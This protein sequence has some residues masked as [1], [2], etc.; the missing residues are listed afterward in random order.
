MLRSMQ[1]PAQTQPT[2]TAESFAGLLATLASPSRE[3]PDRDSVFDSSGLGEDVATLSYERALRAHA[4]Y[5]PEERD[6]W[7]ATPELSGTLQPGPLAADRTGEGLPPQQAS[8]DCDLRTMSVTIRLSKPECARLHQRAAEAGV[9]VSAYLR[10]CT[11]EAEALRAQVKEA[12]AELRLA[13]GRGTEGPRDQG[14]KGLKQ[15]GNEGVRLA[16][17]LAHMGNLWIGLASGKSS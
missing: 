9:T 3:E 15:P 11:F 5:K 12:L 4:R 1:Q 16:R 17:V 6:D 2:S 14:N 8:L 13:A 10:S 7:K